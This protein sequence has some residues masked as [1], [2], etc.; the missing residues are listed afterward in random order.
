MRRRV[1]VCALALVGCLAK[2]DLGALSRQA[3]FE[4]VPPAFLVSDLA[5]DE[6]RRL[7]ALLDASLGRSLVA[8]GY[9]V[10]SEGGGAP[11]VR[12]TWVR[13]A[14]ETAPRGEGALAISFSVFDTQGRRLFSARS[15]RGL[16][17]RA[18]TEDRVAAEVSHLMRGFPERRP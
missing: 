10:A 7:S 9:E 11:L 18:W 12:S 2:S 8:R 17:S 15:V 16:P 14:G 1:A 13:D 3:S 4:L 5:D 6:A